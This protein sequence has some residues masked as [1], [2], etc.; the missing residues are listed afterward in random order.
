MAKHP[1]LNV[2]ADKLG[3]ASIFA[4]ARPIDWDTARGESFA[5]LEIVLPTLTLGAVAE[6]AEDIMSPAQVRAAARTPNKPAPEAL[7]Q[8]FQQSDGYHDW[9]DGFEPMMS[10]VWPAFIPYGMSAQ[11]LADRLDLHAGPVSLVDFGSDDN[12]QCGE[13]YGFAFTGGNMDLSD[14]LAIAYL[15][16]R[17]VPPLQILEG[18][19][20]VIDSYKLAYA[21]ATLKRAYRQAADFMRSRAVGLSRE[22]ARVFAKS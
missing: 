7:A 21:G 5:D 10:Y 6:Y 8:A 11:E 20:G 1:I 15:C 9:A 22:S 17:Q 18:L 12:N 16:A 13:Q 14:Y 4:Q 3:F 2:P 19:G